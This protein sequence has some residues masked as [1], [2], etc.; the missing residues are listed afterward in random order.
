MKLTVKALI[1]GASL[2]AFSAGMAS[3]EISQAD[4]TMADRYLEAA[5]NGDA[6]AQFYLAALYSAGVG[7][8]QSDSEAF[9][10]FLQAA[11]QGHAQAILILS[12]LYAIGRGTAKNNISAYKWA[13]VAASGARIQ[14]T[15]NGARQLIGVLEGRMS[16]EEVQQAKSEAERWRPMPSQRQNPAEISTPERRDVESAPPAR[17]TTTADDSIRPSRAPEP[18]KESSGRNSGVDDLLSRMP[19][20]LRKR[21]GL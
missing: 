17:Q 15:R 10:W 21:L 8:A 20:G 3:A 5:R 12:G 9:H 1:C 4:K 19:P 13:T 18:E 6:T 2:L 14:E 11:Q 16:R 7:R